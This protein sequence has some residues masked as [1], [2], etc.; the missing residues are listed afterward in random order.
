MCCQGICSPE[1]RNPWTT[2]PDDYKPST[3]EPPN[4]HLDWLLDELLSLTRQTHPNVRQASCIWLLSVV[5][6]CGA[7]EPI[8]N[9]LQALQNVF[10]DLLCENNGKLSQIILA[11][12]FVL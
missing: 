1:A 7:R 3:N 11:T 6:G 12:C 10:M 4:D 9:R 5:K 2:L 8:T